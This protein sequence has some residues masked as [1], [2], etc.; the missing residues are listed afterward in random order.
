[1][2]LS[3]RVLLRFALAFLFAAGTAV[4][5]EDA[6]TSH[7]GHADWHPNHL[8]VFFGGMT[9]L[10]SNNPTNFAVGAAYERRFTGLWGAEGLADFVLGDHKRTAL[11]AVGPTVRPFTLLEESRSRE[12]LSPLKFSAGP[13]LEFV[14]KKGKR[15]TRH[16]VIRAG[17]GYEIGLGNFSLAPSVYIDFIGETQTNLTYGV[18][19]GRGF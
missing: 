6:A 10:I 7:D 5:S 14:D 17:V 9:P 11:I 12:L 16:F 4:A 15:V 1:M 19:L 18:Y 8:A 3:R 13:G 2:A